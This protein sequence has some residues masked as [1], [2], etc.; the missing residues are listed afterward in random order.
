MN[1]AERS[2]FGSSVA[3]SGRTM[4]VGVPVPLLP[5]AV[6]L[7][8]F[9]RAPAASGFRWRNSRKAGHFRGSLQHTSRM[10]S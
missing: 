4:V 2:Q 1:G 3:V 7:P 9:A 8:A 10:Y 6:G 5:G